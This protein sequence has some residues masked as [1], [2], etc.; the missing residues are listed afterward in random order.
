MV[1]WLV[2]IFRLLI[3]PSEVLPKM[4][5]VLLLY[6]SS[7]PIEFKISAGNL[8]FRNMNQLFGKFPKH[9]NAGWGRK[10]S[11]HLCILKL[12]FLNKRCHTF[13][14][15]GFRM[16]SKHFPTAPSIKNSFPFT[17]VTFHFAV[18]CILGYH[19]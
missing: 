5:Y 10:Y 4:I 6:Q 7:C 11:D 2:Q 1:K 19:K 17:T 13:S 16:Q 3:S 9:E 14:S 8:E 12:D 18:L 15:S